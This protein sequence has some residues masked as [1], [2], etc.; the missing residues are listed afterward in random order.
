MKLF[1]RKSSVLEEAVFQVVFVLIVFLFYS[2]DRNNPQIEF[3]E[4]VFF[5]NYAIAAY[6]LNFLLIPKFIYQKKYF[7][8]T[9]L[10][11]ML[12]AGVIL[13]EEL[14]IE[15]IFFADTRGKRFSNILYTLIDILPPIIILAGFKLAWDAVSKQRELDE[16]KAMVH[17][18]ELQFLKTQI[19][20][21]FLFNN[22]N[23]L[24]GHAIENSSKTPEIILSLSSLLRYMLYECKVEY[25]PLN[26]EIE[27]L[28]NFINLGELQ[29]EG[30]GNVHFNN[31]ITTNSYKIAPLILVVFIENAFKHSASSIT[32]NI[33]IHIDLKLNAEGGLH[34]TCKNSYQKDSNTTELS[35]GIGLKNVQKRLDLI[36]PNAHSLNLNQDDNFYYVE[37]KMNLKDS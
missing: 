9:Y 32:D 25:V 8:F 36:Y 13:V 5:L 21:H 19:N 18:S 1:Q 12:I 10:F 14:V 37:L 17:E 29:I 33:S 34:F 4:F 11:L 6:I 31:E 35:H 3:Y 24:Y 28:Q 15:Q 22:L 23:N 16:L 20:P 2:F 26:K 27:Q 30:R 7:K